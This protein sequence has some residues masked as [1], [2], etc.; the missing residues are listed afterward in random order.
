MMIPQMNIHVKTLKGRVCAK[1][2]K[3]KTAEHFHYHRGYKGGLF[4]WC[5]S[6]Q[7]AYCKKRWHARVDVRDKAR[8]GHR[9][10]RVDAL[11][12]YSPNRVPICACCG[13]TEIKFLC[14]DHINGGGTKHRHRLGR[15]DLY[16]WLKARGYPK[17]YQVLCHNCNC[18]KG[19]Y[20]ECP[21]QANERLH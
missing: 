4:C 1:C 8:E 12:A 14:I 20:G 15:T 3:Y 2:K 5:N 19:F 7:S 10:A 18:A 6:C 21:H 9:R 11:M 16:Y 17:G 13:E